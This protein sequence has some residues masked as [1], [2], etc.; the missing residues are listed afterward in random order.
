M[1][2]LRTA[3]VDIRVRDLTYNQIRN[4]HFGMFF[5]HDP[6]YKT[7]SNPLEYGL[8]PARLDELFTEFPEK[9]Y[10]LEIKDTVNNHDGDDM[11]FKL[12]VQRLIEVVNAHNMNHRVIVASFDDRVIDYVN[13]QSNGS[14]MTGAATNET[15]KFV[16]LNTLR[17]GFFYNP[18]DA[19]LFLPIKDDIKPHQRDMVDKAPKFIINQITTYDE[20]TDT[21]YTDLMKQRII[22]EAKRHN[23]AVIFWT[24]NDE[25]TMRK[26]INM[27][28][29]GI[30]T[31]RPDLL[32]IIL[33]EKFPQ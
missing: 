9:M 31:D 5:E 24:V 13:E 26:L 27:G 22:K 14:L 2:L 12:A 10:I 28:V 11:T 25:E 1:T 21:Y 29:D 18:S 20:I 15:F 32:K 33:D 6:Y 3:G 30:I 23:M 8:I 19:V 7:V 16:I 17:L 4:Y